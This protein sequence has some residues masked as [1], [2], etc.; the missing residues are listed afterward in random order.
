[1][2][3][4]SF[5][6]GQPA[7]LFGFLLFIAAH[8]ALCP[9]WAFAIPLFAIA[10]F[11]SKRVFV[12]SSCALL[13]YLFTLFHVQIPQVERCEGEALVEVQDC[14]QVIHFGKPIWKLNLGISSFQVGGK[15]IGKNFSCPIYWKDFNLRPQGGFLYS[16]RGT[17]VGAED[18]RLSFSSSK[19]SDWTK[20]KK[21]FSLTEWRFRAKTQ[22]K[23]YL[24]RHLEPG[25]G[26]TFLE[27]LISGDF[28]DKLFS[29][30]MRNLGLSHILV[31]SGFHFSLVAAFLSLI[32]TFVASWRW[33]AALLL[34]GTTFYFLFIGPTPSVGRA[35]ISVFILFSGHLLE[36]KSTSLNSLGIALIALMLYDSTLSLHIGFQLSFLATFAIL[37]FYP[38]SDKFLAKIFKERPQQEGQKMAFV[39]QLSYITMIFLRK[40]LSLSLAVYCV[41]FPFCLYLFHSVPYLGLLY[42]IFFPFCTSLL[43]FF[44]GF[45]L[46]LS[47]IPYVG[48]ALFFLLNFCTNQA[49]TSVLNCPVWFY[50]SCTVINFP[51][52]LLALCL[53]LLTF[54]AIR[55][56]QRDKEDLGLLNYF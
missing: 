23:L 2:Y 52:A 41:M 12:A 1:M 32:L 31:V 15:S 8:H 44:F 34:C 40:G 11:W 17:L 53:T 24:R 49:L 19:L 22:F 21:T 7:L 51:D 18:G 30:K 43:M 47:P 33:R 37:L 4:R 26:R 45:C 3:L 35:W 56:G 38:I 36:K 20:V 42:N 16:V 14:T 29:Q 50:E 13:F 28:Q 10:L 5:W 6:E 27:G 48:Q 39:D 9:H 54:L 55:L 46:L 25:D